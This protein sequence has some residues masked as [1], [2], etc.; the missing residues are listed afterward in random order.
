VT[1]QAGNTTGGKALVYVDAHVNSYALGAGCPC[2]IRLDLKDQ[3][4]ITLSPYIVADMPAIPA[5]DNDT[6]V[7]TGIQGYAVVPTGVPRTFSVVARRTLG[8]AA[9]L[10]YGKLDAIYVPFDGSGGNPAEEAPAPGAAS[11][12]RGR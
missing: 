8:T 7:V 12:E 4:G 9:L 3:D 10:P 5:G 6:D 1:I 11:E 2:E